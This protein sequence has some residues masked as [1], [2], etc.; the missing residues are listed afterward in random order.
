[1]Q[2]PVEDRGRHNRI[3]EHRALLTDRTIAGDQ[4]AA[5]FVAA[6]HQLE[7]QVRGVRLERQVA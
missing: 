6:R 3:A 1:M 5:A 7:E 4:H 2:E